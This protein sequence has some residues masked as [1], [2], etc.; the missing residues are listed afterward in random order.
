MTDLVRYRRPAVLDEIAIDGPTVIEASAG[1]GKTF[2][3]EHLVLELLLRTDV[4]IDGILIVT[5][6]DKATREMRQRIR[7]KVADILGARPGDEGLAAAGESAWEVDAAARVRLLDAWRSFDRAPIST[8]HGFCSR[9]L[10]EHAFHSGGLFVQ[11]LADSRALF[12]RSM[13]EEVRRALAEGG[14]LA[15]A[16]RACFGG[17]SVADVEACL[18]RWVCERG[19][20]MPEAPPEGDDDPFPLLVHQLVPRVRRRIVEAKAR[21]GQMDFDDL[22]VR[23]RDALATAEGERLVRRLRD[24]FRYCLVDEFQDTDEVQWE[25]FRR[26]FFETG[27]GHVLFAIGDPKQAIYSFRGADVHTYRAARD[28]IAERGRR[29]SLR[30]N[31]RSTADVIEAQNLLFADGFFQGAIRYEPVR[32]GRPE[33]SL[34]DAA[35]APAPPVTLVGL[36]DRQKLTVGPVRQA[37]Y[38]FIAEECRRVVEGGALRLGAKGDEERIAWSDIHVLVR[39]RSEADK[40]GEA[41]RAHGVPHAFFKQDGLFQTAQARDVR[42]VLAAVADPG[43]R[44][45]RLRAWLTP[46]FA[47]RLEDLPTEGQVEAAHPLLARL[48]H[49]KALAGG[50]DY[51]GLFRALLEE[52]GVV[53]R[54]LFLER[55][56]RAL[57]NY[58]HLFEILLAETHRRRRSLPELVAHLTALIDQRALPGEEDGNVQRLESERHAVQ[59]LTMHKA[60]GLEAAVIFVA[61]GFSAHP[62]G[63]L[64]EPKVCHR[65]GVREAWLGKPPPDVQAI[66]EQ[67]GR[68]EDERLLYVAVTRAK[69]RVYL[70]YFGPPPKHA[71]PPARAVYSFPTLRGCY[72]L[73]NQRLA[74]LVEAEAAP[75]Q[76]FDYVPRH[77]GG[78][79]PENAALERPDPGPWRPEP[80][81]L[82]G[83]GDG[84]PVAWEA[85]RARHAAPVITSYTRIK[86]GH[87]GYASPDSEDD[88]FT[89]ESVDAAPAEVETQGLP[90]G[91]SVGVFLHEVLE[92]LDFP[93]LRDAEALDGWA[94]REEVA[95]VFRSSA[96]RNGVSTDHLPDAQRMVHAAMRAPLHHGPLAL[97][98]GLCTLEDR[99]AEMQLCYPIPERVHPA[100]NAPR[101]PAAEW[102]FEVERG[103]IRGVVDLVFEHGGRVY[104]LDYKSDRLP[105]FDTATLE[106]HVARNY[107][108]QAKL[109]AIGVLRLLDV[110]DAADYE[111]RFGGLLY[112]FLRGMHRDGE[113][114]TF[115]RPRFE[116]V[117]AWEEAMRTEA[118]PFGYRLVEGSP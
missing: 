100:L 93:A 6:T 89:G 66:L 35:G 67:E 95:E 90:G 75:A 38:G 52:S 25:I 74:N 81:A 103:F 36:H 7:R 59:I 1:T 69:G 44:S 10:G 83:D 24:R 114:V 3:L 76:L 53:R 87:G 37:L 22:L 13:R 108:L 84:E 12:E 20:L 4:G 98:G 102:P 18:Y 63:G 106:R 116:D 16:A 56:E 9:V 101:P 11:E 80:N 58:L 68:E 33:Q 91:S 28:V 39:S 85:L 34:V 54:E 104:F 30:D 94:A 113:G 32:C 115:E 70:P 2:T 78:G 73:L 14:A 48:Y 5:F 105:A 15:E 57:T 117:V 88:A 43:D 17:P 92:H 21:T 42:D 111:A 23:L 79:A 96:R 46:F 26:V 19:R 64:H 41:M 55:S 110:R 86:R 97:P 107:A 51:P 49:L 61:G 27:Q 8:I 40:V 45:L 60:K 77:L 29:V 72:R 82:T 112:C 62:G 65:E 50:H 71:P 99:V 47:L 109:Y 31:Y 118:A